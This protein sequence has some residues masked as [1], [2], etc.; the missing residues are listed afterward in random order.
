MHGIEAVLEF[1]SG[2]C[3]RIVT[4]AQ[5]WA[6]RGCWGGDDTPYVIH[7]HFDVSREGYKALFGSFNGA[8][9]SVRHPN[10]RDSYHKG[11][12]YGATVFCCVVSVVIDEIRR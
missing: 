1:N 10:L 6:A 9:H 8:F 11:Q 7:I 4:T 2:I 3:P 5:A 12:P